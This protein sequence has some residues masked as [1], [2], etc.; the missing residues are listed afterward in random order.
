MR[1][2]AVKDVSDSIMRGP[3]G[4]PRRN[5]SPSC[6]PGLA[7]YP[8]LSTFA[9][10]GSGC[11]VLCRRAF[12]FLWFNRP[13]DFPGSASGLIDH[14]PGAID[15]EPVRLGFA[16]AQSL[17]KLCRTRMYTDDFRRKS[18]DLVETGTL[19]TGSAK[20][21][22][23]WRHSRLPSTACGAVRIGPSVRSVT[24]M[25]AGP[26]TTALDTGNCM[27][28]RQRV[29]CGGSKAEGIPGTRSSRTYPRACLNVRPSE[30]TGSPVEVWPLLSELVMGTRQRRSDL[31][32][33]KRL[34]F[35]EA[36]LP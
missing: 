31:N 5:S 1:A 36:R 3:R 6:P 33:T 15:E 22:S 28:S 24:P 21:Y 9:W 32:R 26:C 14:D 23:P 20:L 35:V 27:A 19:Q 25:L 29:S 11:P 17:V 34:T 7:V 4:V 13:N 30:A 10:S 12:G 16:V 18:N 2:Q 8:P